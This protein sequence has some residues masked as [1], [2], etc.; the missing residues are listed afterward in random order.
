M[1]RSSGSFR[2]PTALAALVAVFLLF[3]ASAVPALAAA[4]NPSGLPVPRFVT[5]RSDPINVRVGPG[6]KYDIAW[7]YVKAGLPVEIIA[8]FDVWRKIRDVDGSEGW[9][10]QNLLVGNRS[11]YVAPWAKGEQI[12]LRTRAGEDA[13]VRAYLTPGFKVDIA[14][15][16]GQWCAVSATDHPASGRPSTYSGYLPQSEL[17]GVYRNEKFD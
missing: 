1:F 9:V 5:T 6:T 13:G 7:V 14:S 8:E 3:S 4:D 17:W 15:C 10:H 12:P 2:L 16:D 11:G